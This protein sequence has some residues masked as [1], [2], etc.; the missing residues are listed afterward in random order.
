VYPLKVLKVLDKLDMGMS[1]AVVRH[2]Y[3]VNKSTI[4]YI[5]K[6]KYVEKH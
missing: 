2:H 5:K 3:G 4:C 6:N 1:I